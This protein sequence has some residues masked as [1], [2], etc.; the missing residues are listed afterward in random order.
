MMAGKD[1]YLCCCAY[2]YSTGMKGNTRIRPASLRADRLCHEC[3]CVERRKCRC[4][5]RESLEREYL[6]PKDLRLERLVFECLERE[7]RER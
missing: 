2:F 4:D 7:R 1:I 6:S 5:E 3:L